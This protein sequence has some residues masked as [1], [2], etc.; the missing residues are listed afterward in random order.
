MPRLNESAVDQP[1]L[2]AAQIARD[3]GNDDP[4]GPAAADLLV[5]LQDISSHKLIRRHRTLA[6]E[7]ELHLLKAQELVAV[8]VRELGSSG[9]QD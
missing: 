4:L 5:Y 3:L 6:L 8:L 1:E 2:T 9:E 7:A